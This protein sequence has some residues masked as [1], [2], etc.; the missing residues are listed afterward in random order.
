MGQP[1]RA[2]A[3]TF[4]VVVASACSEAASQ[5][6]AVETDA[7]IAAAPEWS[8][9]QITEGLEVDGATR[10]RIDEGLQ[11]LHASMLDLHGRW[12]AAEALDG[13]EQAAALETLDADARALHDRHMALWNALDDDVRETLAERMHERMRGHE[14][15]GH[16]SLHD[17]MKR[18]HGAVH[19][20][21]VGH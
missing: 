13:A 14:M 12:T 6:T 18:L 15:D 2:L 1:V 17:R 8:P 11:S 19:D 4:A 16:D 10:R 21:V 20:A 3:V 5:P 7:L 9:A